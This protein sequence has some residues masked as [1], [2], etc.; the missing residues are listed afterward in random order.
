MIICPIVGLDEK[1]MRVTASGGLKVRRVGRKN[2]LYSRSSAKFVG[3]FCVRYDVEEGVVTVGVGRVN[4]YEP[5][6]GGVPISGLYPDG[7]PYPDGIPKIAVTGNV[8]ICLKITPNQDTG[9]LDAGEDGMAAEGQLTVVAER[10]P[11]IGGTGPSW[12]QTLARVSSLG[13]IA[14][15]AYFNYWYQA[16][17]PFGETEWRHL[18]TLD[19]AAIK[20]LDDEIREEKITSGTLE[21]GGL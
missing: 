12:Y 5:E 20:T 7:T 19:D 2:V 16:Y 9:R 13:F 3:R 1:P 8:S 4:E 18:I 11:I 17:K 15:V 6:I 14:Q 21:A 10:G